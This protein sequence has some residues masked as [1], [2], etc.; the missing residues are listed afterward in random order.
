MFKYYY[1]NDRDEIS[2]INYYAVVYAPVW[3]FLSPSVSIWIVPGT[4]VDN[5]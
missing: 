3:D 5:G 1:M 4:W 2:D